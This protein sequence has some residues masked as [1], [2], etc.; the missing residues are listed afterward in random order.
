[1]SLGGCRGAVHLGS[2]TG[3]DVQFWMVAANS[4]KKQR[5]DAVP[6]FINLEGNEQHTSQVNLR[7]ASELVPMSNFSLGQ[8]Q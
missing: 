5:V 4:R 2:G 3:A 6:N 7:N 1:M 8:R